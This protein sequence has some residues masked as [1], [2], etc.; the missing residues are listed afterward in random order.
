MKR[1]DYEDQNNDYDVTLF[2]FYSSFA[3][4]LYD[5]IKKGQKD[6]ACA[7]LMAAIEYSTSIENEETF[8][9]SF[10]EMYLEY[11]WKT[12]RPNIGKSAKDLARWRRAQ[13]CKNAKNE[14][15]HAKNEVNHAKSEQRLKEDKGKK[16]KDKN[17]KVETEKKKDKNKKVKTESAPV[18]SP[19]V[20]EKDIIQFYLDTGL[21]SKFLK[22]D[23]TLSDFAVKNITAYT[24]KNECGINT[25]NF[26]DYKKY[27]IACYNK[28]KEGAGLKGRSE[29]G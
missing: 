20:T 26:E 28:A 22:A 7:L 9:S 27:A 23:M 17:K 12:I 1:I 29:D 15:N 21:Q 5:F 4:I 14:V 18:L 6:E 10:S 11:V 25:E 24:E 16:K 2:K 13:E 19:V 8:N 3:R